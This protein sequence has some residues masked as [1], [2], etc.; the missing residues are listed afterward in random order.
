ML[1][2]HTAGSSVIIRYGL[3]G[4]ITVTFD[5]ERSS[6]A[7][8]PAQVVAMLQ[9]ASEPAGASGP[10]AARTAADMLR[11]LA[12]L[13]GSG[14]EFTA[15]DVGCVMDGHMGLYDVGWQDTAAG[16][17]RLADRLDQR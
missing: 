13:I 11:Q 3:D 2:R 6:P 1:T 14:H 7:E 9:P 10:D 16:L 8:G 5:G 15:G 4:S 12:E 17:E